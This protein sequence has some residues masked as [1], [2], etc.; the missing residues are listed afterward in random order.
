MVSHLL[1]EKADLT[2][3]VEDHKDDA[4]ELA[5]DVA[6]YSRLPYKELPVLPEGGRLLRYPAGSPPIRTR[7]QAIPRQISRSQTVAFPLN[8]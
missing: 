8:E 1:V 3:V 5:E 6:L 2:L 7:S 4:S